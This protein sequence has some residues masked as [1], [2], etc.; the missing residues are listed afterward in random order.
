MKS[1]FEYGD[2]PAEDFE[3]TNVSK[4]ILE[5]VAITAMIKTEVEESNKAFKSEQNGE[6]LNLNKLLDDL[7][8]LIGLTKVKEEV[9]TLINLVTVRKKRESQGLKTVPISLHLVFSGNPGTGKTTVARILAQIYKELGVLSQGQL[10]ETD[11]SGLVA[12]YVGQTALKT[13]EVIQKAKGGILF[14][15]EAYSL[16]SA[17]DSDDFGKEAIDT[18]LKAMEDMRDDFIVIV[19]GYP[20]L[21]NQFLK[22]NPGLESRFNNFIDF[23]DYKPKDL[24]EIFKHMC[25]EKD[26]IISENLNTSLQE[27]FNT[28]YLNRDD[29][30]ANARTVRN[31]F[32]NSIKKQ[33]N[34]VAMIRNPSKQDLQELIYEDLL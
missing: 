14:I 12:G 31:V 27:Y 8:S 22:S 32:E 2:Y 26:F 19:A 6:N 28:L 24:V 4:C 10:I 34:R 20:D 11:R 13:Q 23:E 18:L 9:N 5:L 3:Y 15:D 17:R 25:K 7:N 16:A 21:M 33:A 29:S 30:Y 1:F